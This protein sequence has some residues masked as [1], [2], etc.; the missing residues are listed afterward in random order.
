MPLAAR[1]SERIMAL[2][3]VTLLLL[4]VGGGDEQ[5]RMDVMTLS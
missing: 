5:I 4:V 3:C 2:M 1:V